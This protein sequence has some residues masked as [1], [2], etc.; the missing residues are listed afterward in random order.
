MEEKKPVGGQ[1]KK[2][3]GFDK[4]ALILGFVVDT[5]TLVSILLS[6][7]AGNVAPSIRGL[8]SPGFAFVIWLLAVYTY[9]AFLHSYWDR[10]KAVEHYSNR[11]GA[12]LV[13]DLLFKFR[14]PLAL[15]PAFISTITLFWILYL[16]DASGG[17][18][19]ASLTV[20]VL[21]GIPGLIILHGSMSDNQPEGMTPDKEL[22]KLIEDNWA[23]LDKKISL[24][25]SRKPW[26]HETDLDD[27]AVLWGYPVTAMKRVLVR[28]AIKHPAKATYGRVYKDGDF[29]PISG[30]EKVLINFK[31][32]D[33]SY[34][35]RS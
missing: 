27:V 19:G 16:L 23:V 28:Y 29:V 2:L 35:Y 15:F 22:E 1:L 13:N 3:L 18:F 4:I 5:V 9:F 17:L 10:K 14:N 32:L 34:Y 21:I 31:N 8:I 7:S 20:L 11:F 24:E 12:F 30:S 26:V 33:S 6:I 25:L